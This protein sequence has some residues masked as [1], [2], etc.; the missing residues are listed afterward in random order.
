MQLIWQTG[1]ESMDAIEQWPW[2]KIAQQAEVI[3]AE[4]AAQAKE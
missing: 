2:W 4:Q 3:L 1:R